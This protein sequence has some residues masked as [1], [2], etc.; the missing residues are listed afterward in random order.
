MSEGC[1][2]RCKSKVPQWKCCLSGISMYCSATIAFESLKFHFCGTPSRIGRRD[3][4]VEEKMEFV[5]KSVSWISSNNI[6]DSCFVLNYGYE[7]PLP[8]P[9][10]WIWLLKRQESPK[11]NH[12]YKSLLKSPLKYF[13]LAFCLAFKGTLKGTTRLLLCLRIYTRKGTF[14]VALFTAT[15]QVRMRLDIAD[16]GFLSVPGSHGMNVPSTC[17]IV[18]IAGK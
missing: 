8:W 5:K 15:I 16:T 11:P 18:I 9:Q 14:R 4:P 3:L 1:P 6:M 12:G 2:F 17:T 10:V 13:C 7:F